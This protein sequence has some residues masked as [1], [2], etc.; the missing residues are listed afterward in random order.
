MRFYQ[1]SSWLFLVVLLGIV[2]CGGSDKGKDGAGDGS[3]AG[4]TSGKANTELQNQNLQSSNTPKSSATPDPANPKTT[5]S[6]PQIEKKATDKHVTP[7]NP[8]APSPTS[9]IVVRHLKSESATVVYRFGGD[10]TEKVWTGP[11]GLSFMPDSKRLCVFGDSPFNAII[12]IPDKARLSSPNPSFDNRFEVTKISG[13]EWSPAI[14]ANHLV[15][16]LP[17]HDAAA[18]LRHNLHN[19][20]RTLGW[21]T[22][23]VSKNGTYVAIG[24][25][26]KGRLEVVRVS[27]GKTVV[28][29]DSSQYRP[30]PTD[31]R[32]TFGGGGS[33]TDNLQYAF[34]PDETKVA[35][36]VRTNSTPPRAFS[37]HSR[38]EFRRTTPKDRKLLPDHNG[39]QSR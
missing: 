15:D 38:N 9:S 2:G 23:D 29:F 24:D 10:P 11:T 3:N 17:L 25:R 34:S 30:K 8:T 32:S 13:Y 1:A 36:A 31:D 7:P 21:H 35:L 19:S 20:W 12:S 14:A 5:K 28:S 26:H 22:C 16:N 6:E 4:T 18:T 39:F 37:C 27:D 33:H